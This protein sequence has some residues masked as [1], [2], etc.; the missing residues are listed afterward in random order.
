MFNPALPLFSRLLSLFHGWLPLLLIWLVK[1]VGYD[2]RAFVG[3]TILGVTLLLTCY[4]ISPLPPAA[5]D[6]ANAAVNVNYV[7]GP[8]PHAIEAFVD[9]RLWLLML[10]AALVVVGY[11]PAH[12]IFSRVFA[13]PDSAG[14]AIAKE[15]APVVHLR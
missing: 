5:A 2:R 10:C 11:L 1:R 6:N 15:E 9:P 7:F 12:A 14:E 13:N 8:D 3:Q 4:F